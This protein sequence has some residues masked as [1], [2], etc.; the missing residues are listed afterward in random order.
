[1]G[2]NWG[3][4]KLLSISIY[5]GLFDCNLDYDLS[6]LWRLDLEEVLVWEGNCVGVSD[7]GVKWIF[8]LVEVIW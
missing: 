4:F 2:M 7:M 1:M 5:F 3:E 6:Y 8:V